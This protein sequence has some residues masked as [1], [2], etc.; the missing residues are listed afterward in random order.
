M[1]IYISLSPSP[2]AVRTAVDRR[3]AELRTE[4]DAIRQ[5]K[6]QSSKELSESNSQLQ[7]FQKRSKWFTC[8]ELGVFL[9]KINR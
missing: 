4:L 2:R 6:E 8:P 7:E 9:L 1:H 5:E 3:E